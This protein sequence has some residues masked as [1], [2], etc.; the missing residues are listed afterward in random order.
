MERKI[1]TSVVLCLFAGLVL[2]IANSCIST[3]P[4]DSLSKLDLSSALELKDTLKLSSIAWKIEYI[5]LETNENSA[6]KPLDQPEKQIK[7][8]DS[9]IIIT[10]ADD[11]F[12]FK[13]DGSFLYKIGSKGR[14]PGEHFGISDIALSA[15]NDTLFVQST[16]VNK[17]LIYNIDGVYLHDFK[18]P[19]NPY[20]VFCYND[21]LVFY[22]LRG[23]RNYSDYHALTI[24][25][26]AGVVHKRMIDR[27][28]EMES[29]K[30]EP[31]GLVGDA[32]L[33][34]INGKLYYFETGYDTLYEISA[35]FDI[36]NRTAISF[37]KDMFPLDHYKASVLE[38]IGLE[39]LQKYIRWSYYLDLEKFMFFEGM[40]KGN[41][42]RVVYD[43]TQ[44]K[45]YTPEFLDNYSQKQNAIL[46]DLDHTI[47]FWP[48]GN[49][50]TTKLYRLLN[51]SQ[52]KTSLSKISEDSQGFETA[53]AIIKR[54][55]TDQNNLESPV[56][57]V[58]SL[59]PELL[60]R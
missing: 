55:T 25:D 41:R 27:S 48:H 21:K 7:F 29:M 11:L 34:S 24:T 9:L 46:N 36:L 28:S 47:S 40:N 16:G 4:K 59:N 58:V 1:N 23:W 38:Y 54:L 3:H 14:G 50:G 56:L 19:F 60:N 18:T 33:Y 30:G 17:L 5:I 10:D 13:T 6:F 43:K 53:Q 42:F 45:G 12:V 51:G 49:I 31:P 44:K 22:T 39:T 26:M 57:M 37:G 52:L 35:D 2:Q 32:K 20:G 8:T 15:S